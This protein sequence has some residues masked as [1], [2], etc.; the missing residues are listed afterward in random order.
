MNKSTA[1]QQV[2]N[3][4]ERANEFLSSQEVVKRALQRINE[5]NDLIKRMKEYDSLSSDMIKKDMT[6]PQSS[7]KVIRKMKSSTIVEFLG[8]E[9]W[10]GLNGYK[11]RDVAIEVY[12]RI[13]ERFET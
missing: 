6:Y 4:A 13:R 7:Y 8:E 2:L 1:L 3:E 10:L 5:S 11:E 9:F 12:K